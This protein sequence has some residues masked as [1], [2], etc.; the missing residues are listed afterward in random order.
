MDF[1]VEMMKIDLRKLIGDKKGK[2]AWGITGAGHLIHESVGTIKALLEKGYNVDVFFSRAGMEVAKMFGQYIVLKKL[3]EEYKGS[4]NLTLPEKQGWSFP[5]CGSFSLK[6][7]K[8][9]IISPTTANSVAK[10]SYKIADTL[11]TNIVSQSLKG[12]IPVVIIPTD[13]KVGPCETIAPGNKKI[14]IEIHE[15]DIE[16]TN[17][18]RKIKGISIIERP[19]EIIF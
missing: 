6:V 7:Y 18:I 17:A 12:E 13:F 2:I 14:T 15:S 5:I 4:I 9:L 3:K 10:I 11:I 19:S 1:V 16:R 8:I